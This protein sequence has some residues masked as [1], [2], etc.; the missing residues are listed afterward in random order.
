MF[1]LASR[2]VGVYKVNHMTKS[3]TVENRDYLVKQESRG[4]QGSQEQR[5]QQA[6]L[7]YTS[8]SPRDG[9]LSRMPS[10]A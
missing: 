2:L 4:Q 1:E 5:S 8:P 9:L 7:L 3:V 6:C 10:S